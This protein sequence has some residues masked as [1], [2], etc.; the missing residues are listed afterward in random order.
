MK[1]RNFLFCTALLYSTHCLAIFCP[2]NFHT[3]NIGD[4]IEQVEAQCGRGNTET[5]STSEANVPQQWTYFMAMQ[6]PYVPSAAGSPQEG[7]MQVTF[8][9]VDNKVVSLTSNGIGVGATTICNSVNL[10]IGSSTD[11]VK[12]ACGK[13]AMIQQSNLSQGSAQGTPASEIIE[14][15]YDTNPPITLRFE[16]GVLKERK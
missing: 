12:K 9:F 11:D 13:P 7:T 4:S 15:K 5:K 10:Q 16:N 8:S 2:T 6:N 3:I 1:L 14:W